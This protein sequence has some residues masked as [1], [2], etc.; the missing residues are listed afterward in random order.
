MARTI[1]VLLA[2]LVASGAL[3][4]LNTLTATTAY[5]QEPPNPVF[6]GSVPDRG[7]IALIAAREQ[8]EVGLLLE[9]IR[10]AGCEPTLLAVATGGVLQLFTPDAPDFVNAAFPRLLTAG[11]AAIVR[12]AHPASLVPDAHLLR[13]VSKDHPLPPNFVPDELTALPPDLV[14]PGTGQPR[15]TEETAAALEHLL[16]AAAEAGHE[17]V[18]RSAYRSYEEQ[19]VTYDYWVRTLG[20]EEANRR[21]ARPGHS[22]HQLGTVVDLTSASVGWELAP[23][24]GAT[25]EGRWLAQHAWT[26]GFV[27][28]YPEGA[29]A[30][31]GYRYEPWH[32]RYIGTTHTEWLRLTD[33]TLTEYLTQLHEGVD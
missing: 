11:R 6:A 16:E 23:E 19:V 18:V 5:A 22:E 25:P 31:T 26:F 13:L 17:L 2:L 30:V 33:L 14:L 24:F 32:L 9:A 21:S 1:T 29:E 8:I 27:E 7:G 28:S 10:T 3:G 4:A 12:C 20:E 15:L